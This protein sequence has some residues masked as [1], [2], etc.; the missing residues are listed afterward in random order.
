MKAAEL[1][2]RKELALTH[3]RIART[4]LLLARMQAPSYLATADATL[5]LA[6][7]V[8]AQRGL[9]RWGQYAR[10][11]LRFARVAL[12]VRKLIGPSGEA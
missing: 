4:E 8:L 5:D 9:G 10:L 11:G 2:L 3:L 6:A 1:A 7:V 12:S